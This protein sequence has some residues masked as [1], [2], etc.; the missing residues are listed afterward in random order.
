MISI[1]FQL[2]SIALDFSGMEKDA[3]PSPEE[4]ARL[5]QHELN[6]P[7]VIELDESE[8]YGVDELTNYAM[9]E[10]SN[11]SGWCVADCSFA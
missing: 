11:R 1:T 8:T 4:Q 7:V 3:T 2:T 9:D 6:T 5:N 10:I